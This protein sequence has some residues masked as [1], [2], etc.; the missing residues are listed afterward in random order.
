MGATTD[1]ANLNFH[2]QKTQYLPKIWAD[3]APLKKD[4]S[5]TMIE[6]ACL[7]QAR[8]LHI[9]C[10]RITHTVSVLLIGR[11]FHTEDP[12]GLSDSVKIF[13]CPGP[14]PGGRHI[15]HHDCM[16]MVHIIGL[17]RAYVLC[18]HCC[19]DYQENNCAYHCLVRRL[20]DSGYVVSTARY[21]YGPS[22]P[23]PCRS[24]SHHAS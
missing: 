24:R 2:V 11:S 14:L 3:I 7:K 12:Y 15:S 18:L 16:V 8:T 17:Q 6:T 23:P 20:Q 22:R 21:D 5:H 19:A 13:M 10:T 4:K 9:K 1:R